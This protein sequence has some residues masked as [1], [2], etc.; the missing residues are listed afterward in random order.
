MFASWVIFINAIAEMKPRPCIVLKRVDRL[1]IEAQH[2]PKI[3]KPIL[4]RLANSMVHKILA[5]ENSLN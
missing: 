1:Q 5:I 4:V 3:H 2:V